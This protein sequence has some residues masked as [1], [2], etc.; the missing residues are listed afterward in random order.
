MLLNVESIGN[1]ESLKSLTHKTKEV[2][3][4]INIKE[5]EIAVKSLKDGKA[6]GVYNT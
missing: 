2:Q 3:Q 1:E 5:L 6:G 4:E